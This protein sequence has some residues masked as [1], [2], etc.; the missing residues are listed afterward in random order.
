M[1]SRT[2]TAH[3]VAIAAVTLL[4]WTTLAGC[5][6]T[7]VEE[8]VAEQAE[9]E[10]KAASRSPDVEPRQYLTDAIALLENGQPDEA[11]EAL[12]TY[13]QDEPDSERARGLLQQIVQPIDTY[14]PA[15]HFEVELASGQSLSTLARTY[16]DDA[17]QFFAL[18]RYNGIENPS[19]VKEGAKIRIPATQH[20]LAVR[21]AL[22]AAGEPAK[23]LSRAD[24]LLA[25]SEQHLANENLQSAYDTLTE[26]VA[27]DP[28]HSAARE[29]LASVKQQLIE[30]Y[31]HAATTAF[32]RQELEAT[33]A[34]CDRVLALDPEH[35]N[36]KLYK[37]Q[38]QDLQEKL[39]ALSEQ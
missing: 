22:P 2:R 15:E 13:L 31:Y 3:R 26:A 33:V 18:A 24:Q 23:P 35:A 10:A 12:E 17:L 34:N 36:A 21:A 32:Q 25:L 6:A 29:S 8:P 5:Q 27:A 19:R 39:A 9:P 38:A 37:A 4:L 11:R 14:F 30:S 1:R 20:A 28:K 16:L 7:G